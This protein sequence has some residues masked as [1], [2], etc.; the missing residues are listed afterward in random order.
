MAAQNWV[1]IISEQH[2]YQGVSYKSDIIVISGL[3][4]GDRQALEQ[5]YAGCD[6]PCLLDSSD[7]RFVLK[8]VNYNPL[9]VMNVLMLRRG[10]KVEGDPQQRTLPS[11]HHKDDNYILENAH[12]LRTSSTRVT[13]ELAKS[14][15]RKD[16]DMSNYH[17]KFAIIYHMSKDVP[18]NRADSSCIVPEYT[19]RSY[20]VGAN[21][22]KKTVPPLPGSLTKQA[23]ELPIRRYR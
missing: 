20:S 15:I 23:S 5:R 9:D 8:G 6:P 2:R 10:Y 18:R 12:N 3:D 14:L 7:G 1:M 16:S 19:P 21:T 13:K 11:I 17:Q 22:K 4:Q